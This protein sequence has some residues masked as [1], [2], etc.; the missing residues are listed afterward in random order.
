M[1]DSDGRLTPE[2]KA[3]VQ[4]RLEKDQGKS[5][6]DRRIT[7]RDVINVFKDFKVPVSGFMYLGLIVPAYSYAF[8]APGKYIV[9]NS[10]G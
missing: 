9:I 3:Y 4:N 6:L 2:E 7:P 5:G 10:F 1:T 8:F